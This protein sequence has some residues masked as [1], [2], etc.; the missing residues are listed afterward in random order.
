M[1]KFSIFNFQFSINKS[2]IVFILLFILLGFVALQIPLST[3]VGS[4]VKFTLFDLLAPISGTFLGTGLGVVAVFLMQFVNLLV[5]GF[6]SFDKGAIIRLFPTLFAVWYFAWVKKSPASKKI[7]I[8]P[9]LSMLAF[10]L[11]PIGRTVWFYSL[12]WLIPILVWPLG[13][14]FL[15]LRSLGATFTAHAVGGAIWI[16]VFNLPAAVWISLIP[17]VI[18]ERGIFAL[19]ISASYILMNN[20]LAYLSSKKLIPIGITLDKKYLLKN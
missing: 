15:V 7:L 10:N 1:K 2:R 13:A 18:M 14:R 3:L 8:I 11:H 20:V 17:V 19:G 4:S 12:F 5:H 9:L 16:W 6:G